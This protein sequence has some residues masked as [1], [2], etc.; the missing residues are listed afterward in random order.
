MAEPLTIVIV[1]DNAQAADALAR[2]FDALGH[3]AIA[4]Y[5]A[6][7]TLAHLS[8]DRPDVMFVD[9]GM[10]VVDGYDL[11]RMICEHKLDTMPIVA[12]TGYG[13]AEDKARAK[14]A[15]FTDHLTKPIGVREIQH[16]LASHVR[17]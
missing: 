6:E 14:E 16:V 5:S 2:L 9:I 7:D 11:L 13:Q 4:R 3:R 10:P 1:D 8:A 15:G 12:L 17:D